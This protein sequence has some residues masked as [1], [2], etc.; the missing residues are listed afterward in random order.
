MQS[1][2]G[3]L[4]DIQRELDRVSREHDKIK[5]Q[6]ALILD[7]IREARG[8]PKVTL[9][10]PRSNVKQ[11][12]LA[13]LEDAGVVGINATGAVERAAK[14]GVSLE[15]GTV[16]S[17]LSRLKNDGVVTYDGAAYRLSSI[18]D[19]PATVH[20]IRATSVFS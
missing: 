3:R 1:L 8:E 7:M 12:I 6:E 19:S 16:S 11:T 20:P 2:Q 15:R 9:R 17:L 14:N 18:K 10:A 4:E 13:M 5:A